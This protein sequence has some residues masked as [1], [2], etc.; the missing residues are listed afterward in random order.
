MNTAINDNKKRL[1][2]QFDKVCFVAGIDNI[3]KMAILH[4]FGV[5]SCLDLTDTHLEAIIEKLNQEPD[6][7]RKR[8]MAAIGS[9][10]KSINK[11]GDANTIKAIACRA[12]GYDNFNKIPMSRLRDLYYEFGRKSRITIS[13]EKVTSEELLYLSS[14]N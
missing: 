9:W 7:W 11:V 14:M 3:E 6:K 5:E 12:G 13:V 1:I 2:K 8:V 4:Q 10:L